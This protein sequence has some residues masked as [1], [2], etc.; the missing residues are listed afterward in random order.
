MCLAVEC[1]PLSFFLHHRNTLSYPYCL[2]Y[3]H[4]L[5]TI[6][7]I[8]AHHN[9]LFKFLVYYFLK[10]LI[11]NARIRVLVFDY[12]SVFIFIEIVS[13]SILA[14]VTAYEPTPFI[15]PQ[16]P[17]VSSAFLKVNR[18]P[19]PSLSFFISK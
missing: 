6:N 11:Q 8:T 3:L 1:I 13:M 7:H 19:S 15:L 2:Y 10:T 9:P 16:Y 18:N 17:S 5:I 4:S 12:F 14:F